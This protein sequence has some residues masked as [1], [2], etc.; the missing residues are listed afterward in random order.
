VETVVPL[1]AVA[2]TVVLVLVVFQTQRRIWR[3][4]MEYKRGSG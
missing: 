2:L 3:I 4:D 1:A